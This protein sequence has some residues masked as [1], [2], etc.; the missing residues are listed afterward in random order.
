MIGR[1]AAERSVDSRGRPAPRILAWPLIVGLMVAACGRGVVSPVAPTAEPTVGPSSA[2]T[3]SPPATPAGG[4]D[5]ASIAARISVDGLRDRFDAL[6]ATSVGMPGFRALGSDGYDAAADYVADELRQLGWEVHDDAFTTPTFTDPG[7]SKLDVD[8]QTFGAAD[9]RPLIFAPGGDVQGPVVAL[10]WDAS[11]TG[12]TGPGCAVEDYGTLPAGAIV[13]VR[14]GPCRRRDAILAAQAAGAAGFVA[15]YPWADAGNPLRPTLVEPD[16]L[17]I[18]AVGATRPVGDALAALDGTDRKAHLVSRADTADGPTHSI[19]AELPGTDPSSVVMLGAHLDSV[20]DGPGINDNGSGVAAMLE[21]AR[22]LSTEQPR[23]TIRLAFWAAEEVGLQGSANYVGR[24]SSADRAAV[25]A[26]LNADMV[27]SPNGY[28][29]VYREP[30]APK[31]SEVV[32]ALLRAALGAAG[33]VPVDVDVGGASDHYLFNQFG[34]PTGGVFSG[35][36]EIVT[37][38]QAASADAIAGQPADPCYHQACDDG[39]ALD[40][41]LARRLTA[42]LADVAVQLSEDPSLTR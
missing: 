9:I 4:L 18:P 26:Y 28:A 11:A 30:S 27:A 23:S 2:A 35:A 10:D 16:G 34:I 13:L 39:S 6:E 25:A 31:G 41:E 15:V 32:T 17:E 29:A 19:I 1:M 42:A 12:P 14:S 21:I 5:A 7:G 20:I 33:K 36:D 37:P 38:A 22:A 3:A 40:L 8:G 24:L